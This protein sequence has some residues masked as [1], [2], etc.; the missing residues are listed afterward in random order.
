MTGEDDGDNDQDDANTTPNIDMDEDTDDK[1]EDDEPSKRQKIIRGGPTT[2]QD[3]CNINFVKDTVYY[4][5]A[6]SSNKMWGTAKA[7]DPAPVVPM[8]RQESCEPGDYIRIAGESITLKA[9]G[10]KNTACTF[11]PEEE[12]IFTSDWHQFDSDM[13]GED[14]R[15]L[16][17][18]TFLLWWQNIKPPPVPRPKPA[19]IPR[20]TTANKKGGRKR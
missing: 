1:E 19:T 18:T 14:L 11:A 10:N 3:H 7:D 8:F 12:L 4:L 5:L 17:E 16:G 2:N 13:T 15:D 20:K 6:G 9:N